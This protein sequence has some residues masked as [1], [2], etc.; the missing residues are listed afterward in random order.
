MMPTE[1]QKMLGPG[2]TVVGKP[3]RERKA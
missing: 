1:K 3:V 2:A